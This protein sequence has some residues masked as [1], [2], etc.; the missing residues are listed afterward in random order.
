MGATSGQMNL[1]PV[2]TCSHDLAL[3]VLG[4]SS[5]AGVGVENIAY[6][7]APRI[8]ETLHRLTGRPVYWRAAGSNSAVSAEVRDYVVPNL[9]PHPYT[10]IVLTIGTNDAKNF[11]S[12]RR[13]KQG[14]GGLLYALKAKWPDARIVW[15]QPVDARRIPCLPRLLA[16]GLELRASLLREVGARLCRERGVTPAA[17]LSRMDRS[18]FAQDGFHA[19][20]DGYA[21]VADHL[22]R[23]LVDEDQKLHT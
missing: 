15:S 17:P 1:T 4:D 12:V 10:H 7:L 8:A 3:L 11:H 16:L 2:Q 21:F 5:A 22:T 18:G 19:S 20:R 23:Y 9:E 14:F 13:F 6:S